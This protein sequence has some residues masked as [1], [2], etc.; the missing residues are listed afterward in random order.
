MFAIRG[1]RNHLR[2]F[3][4]SVTRGARL[5]TKNVTDCQREILCIVGDSCPVPVP[6]YSFQGIEGLV[7]GGGN[8]DRL[9]VA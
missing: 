8:Y 6:E 2:E 4:V 3:W 1:A 7:N 9:K 5:F